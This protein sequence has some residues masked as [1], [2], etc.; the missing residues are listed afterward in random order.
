M[1]TQHTS[2]AHPIP[3]PPTSDHYLHQHLSAPHLPPAGL[4]SVI[5]PTHCGELSGAI[6]GGVH[7]YGY[8]TLGSQLVYLN[9]GGPRMA[10][11][12]IRAR[13]SRGETIHLTPPDSPAVAFSLTGTGKFEDYSENL[14]QHHFQN[15]MLIHRNLTPNYREKDKLTFAFILAKSPQQ[16]Y[17]TFHQHL[18]KLL[19]I[20]VFPHWIP[21]LWATGVSA[22]IIAVCAGVGAMGY[23][24]YLKLDDWQTLIALGV[25]RGILPLSEKGTVG[26]TITLIDAVTNALPMAQAD[27]RADDYHDP[28]YG[29]PVYRLL[30]TKLP[31]AQKSLLS[32]LTIATYPIMRKHMLDGFNYKLGMHL[33]LYELL[34]AR[35]EGYTRDELAHIANALVELSKTLNLGLLEVY[36]PSMDTEGK[37]ALYRFFQDEGLALTLYN[38]IM[39]NRKDGWR[40]NLFKERHILSII[41][42]H[43]SDDELV[44]KV[45]WVIKAQGEY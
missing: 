26:D 38:A 17:W 22:N 36:P 28:A 34:E 45:F 19:P 18:H 11:E 37:R 42:Q 24:V 39:S 23:G 4:D 13:L 30:Q 44:N 2:Q 32:D 35:L 40:D 25:K 16:V 31:Q 33:A 15:T 43:V 1:T 41:A 14:S 20:A 8:L 3:P 9:M 7:C 21:T 5:A 6:S 10:V 29:D 12:A 27:S